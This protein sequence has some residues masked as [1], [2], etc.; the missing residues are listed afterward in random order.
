ME[1]TF[2]CGLYIHTGLGAVLLRPA[3]RRPQPR[4]TCGRN[5]LWAVAGLAFLLF[6][7]L[8]YL[9]HIGLSKAKPIRSYRQRHRRACVVHGS[10]TGRAVNVGIR[11]ASDQAIVVN[12]EDVDDGDPPRALESL[13]L[14]ERQRPETWSCRSPSRKP[15]RD[16]TAILERAILSATRPLARRR[17]RRRCRG[18]RGAGRR[19]PG[20]G[21]TGP[22]RASPVHHHPSGGL[23]G[24]P[25]P[26]R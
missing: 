16:R 13:K 18:G 22:V 24:P 23:V 26:G 5:R 6:G 11:R 9:N 1:I 25:L 10:T 3:L 8:S 20:A 21:G 19:T 12:V 7:V 2:I 17:V 15:N 14:S 4:R